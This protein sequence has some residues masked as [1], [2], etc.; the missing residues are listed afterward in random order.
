MQGII[1]ESSTTSMSGAKGQGD[2]AVLDQ[3]GKQHVTGVCVTTSHID[4][5]NTHTHIPTHT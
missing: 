4:K 1:K 3:Q 5:H 2:T